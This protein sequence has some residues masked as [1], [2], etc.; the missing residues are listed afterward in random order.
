[1]IRPHRA[2][3]LKITIGADEWP[4]VLRELAEL[5]DHLE[6]HGPTC[7][8]LSGGPSVGHIV[9]IKTD[10]TMTNEIYHERLIA[11]LKWRKEDKT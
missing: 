10:P 8:S 5:V 11:Y 7:S 6:D 2:F 4:Q 9:D 1:M 3:E